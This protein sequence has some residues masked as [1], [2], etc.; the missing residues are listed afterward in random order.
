MLFLIIVHED[1]DEFLLAVTDVICMY[2]MLYLLLIFSWA[3]DFP[4]GHSMY[5]LMFY[6]AM[7]L[8]RP[9]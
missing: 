7:F 8:R 6:F 4:G 9:L 3:K 2:L 5:V 1:Y